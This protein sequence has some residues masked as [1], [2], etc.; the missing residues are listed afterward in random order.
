MII[1]ARAIASPVVESRYFHFSLARVVPPRRR[2]SSSSSL[3]PISCLTARFDPYIFHLLSRA[4]YICIRDASF[5]VSPCRIVCSR[6][7]VR[8]GGS[9]II[10][11]NYTHGGKTGHATGYGV[12]LDESGRMH[13][14]ARARHVSRR[15]C[16]SI[17]RPIIP[18]P[19]I[20]IDST[21]D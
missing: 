1:P 4:R 3:P 11:A 17:C 14:R 9:K 10:N 21:A 8:R 16:M 12:T 20:T 2:L 18:F 7:T 15:S 13:A 5:S 6:Q 19:D